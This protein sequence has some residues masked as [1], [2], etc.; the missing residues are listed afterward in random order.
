M[1]DPQNL[2]DISAYAV[3][4]DVWRPVY[5][6][7][8]RP[9]AASRP[10]KLGELREAGDGGQHTLDLPIGGE[11]DRSRYKLSLRPGL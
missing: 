7:L 8:A 2:D 5:D 3:R 4:R 10:P 6:Q 11:D 1:Q 9:S